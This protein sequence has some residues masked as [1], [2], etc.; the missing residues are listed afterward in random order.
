MVPNK[1]SVGADTRSVILTSL[2]PFT[3]Y[4]IQVSASTSK[5]ESHTTAVMELTDEG[6]E[7]TVV[8]SGLI[9]E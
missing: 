3:L 8:Y 9:V 5:G 7:F 1:R 6:R 4:V 2:K